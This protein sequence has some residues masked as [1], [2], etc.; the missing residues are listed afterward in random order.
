MKHSAGQPQRWEN[1]RQITRGGGNR[2]R[3][4]RKEDRRGD[5][6][7]GGGGGN[8][9]SSWMFHEW[10][11]E[12]KSDWQRVRRRCTH[13]SPLRFSS[14][15]S[16]SHSL[17]L[18]RLPSFTCLSGQP[19]SQTRRGCF[20]PLHKTKPE[21]RWALLRWPSYSS[22]RSCGNWAGKDNTPRNYLCQEISSADRRRGGLWQKGCL[23]LK[24]ENVDGERKENLSESFLKHA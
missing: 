12:D 22:I 2:E 4:E 13:S 10:H 11:T 15:A 9:S 14:S 21:Q 17:S 7:R 20:T 16:P 23:V 24:V 8:V 1:N 19:V 5:G 6:G 18:L 3:G